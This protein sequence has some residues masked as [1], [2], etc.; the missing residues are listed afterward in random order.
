MKIL[1]LRN[2]VKESLFA[3]NNAVIEFE[4]SVKISNSNKELLSYGRMDSFNEFNTSVA[5]V[6]DSQK[7][8]TD[9]KSKVLVDSTNYDRELRNVIKNAK[10]CFLV[11]VSCCT[12]IFLNNS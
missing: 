1:T 10:N 2:K 12:I 9:A 7:K 6:V 8:L 3:V 5:N 11:V 4:S